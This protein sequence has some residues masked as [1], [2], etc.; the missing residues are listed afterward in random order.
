MLK[1][2]VNKDVTRIE[3]EG[4][5][6][7]VCAD[8]TNIIHGLL[9][10]MDKE[11]A[12]YFKF[13]FTRGV[14]EGIVYGVTKK[15]MEGILEDIEKTADTDDVTKALVELHDLLRELLKDGDED[16]DK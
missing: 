4:S 14:L 15:E 3:G 5:V 11:S 1:I 13:A 7:T 2:E 9:K 6:A 12:D 16:E 10:G 8:L